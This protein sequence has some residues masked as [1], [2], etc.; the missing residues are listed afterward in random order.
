[1]EFLNLRYIKYLCMKNNPVKKKKKKK[2]LHVLISPSAVPRNRGT[3]KSGIRLKEFIKKERGRRGREL[4]RYH[5][6][7]GTQ[8]WI[9]QSR[10]RIFMY[11]FFFQR[12]PPSLPWRPGLNPKIKHG[13]TDPRGSWL[14][15]TYA[16]HERET[17]KFKCVV[18]GSGIEETGHVRLG[19]SFSEISFR[20]GF[21]TGRFRVGRNT[22]VPRV[23]NQGN[24]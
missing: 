1:M 18:A 3:S 8:S 13:V 5:M 17:V 21:G 2:V 11:I 19:E 20:S 22:S 9:A 24:M 16:T 10:G 4:K 15:W 6:W 12:I 23:E 14:R 7:N